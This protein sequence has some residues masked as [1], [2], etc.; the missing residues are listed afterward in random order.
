MTSFQENGTFILLSICAFSA[1]ASVSAGDRANKRAMTEKHAD[2]LERLRRW[3]ADKT[4]GSGRLL[5]PGD[6]GG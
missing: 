4:G 6:S 1:A 3:L 2:V 5:G